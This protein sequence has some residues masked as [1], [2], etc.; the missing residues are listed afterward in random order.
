MKVCMCTY[1]NIHITYVNVQPVHAVCLCT[2]VC[3]YVCNYVKI[4]EHKYIDEAL[5]SQ[6][7]P[8]ISDSMDVTEPQL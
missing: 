8:A 4:T 1:M 3:T 5:E 2:Y 7:I 6:S